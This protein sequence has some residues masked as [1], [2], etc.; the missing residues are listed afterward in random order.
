MRVS[1]AAL[2]VLGLACTSAKERSIERMGEIADQACACTS[3]ACIEGLRPQL[4]KLSED[5]RAA[6]IGNDPTDEEGKERAK[7]AAPP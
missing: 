1:T 2:V 6:G 7:P 5:I 3:K 4:Q